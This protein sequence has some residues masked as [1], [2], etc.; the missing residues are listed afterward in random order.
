MPTRARGNETPTGY[1]LQ[2][3]RGVAAVTVITLLFSALC[4]AAAVVVAWLL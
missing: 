3:L 2:G 4:F 1:L